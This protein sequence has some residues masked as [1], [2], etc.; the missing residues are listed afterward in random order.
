MHFI[1]SPHCKGVDGEGKIEG[2]GHQSG[3]ND[4]EECCSSRPSQ[5]CGGSRWVLRGGQGGS[6][7]ERKG[8]DGGW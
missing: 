3:R 8:E 6:P 7:Q 2:D 5:V 1:S 4:G